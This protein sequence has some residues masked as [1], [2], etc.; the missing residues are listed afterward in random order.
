MEIGQA[1]IMIIFAI[2][3]I[4]GEG[5]HT[6]GRI[7]LAWAVVFGIGVV[8]IGYIGFSIFGALLWGI[9]RWIGIDYVEKWNQ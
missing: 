2:F 9:K 7:G 8:A 5:S 4:L 3:G 1:G 6:L